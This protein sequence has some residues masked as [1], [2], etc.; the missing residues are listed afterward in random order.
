MNTLVEGSTG[1]AVLGPLE[2]RRG[3]ARRQESIGSPFR[4]C[5]PFTPFVVPLRGGGYCWEGM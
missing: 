2:E 5:M 3:G 4:L 1:D